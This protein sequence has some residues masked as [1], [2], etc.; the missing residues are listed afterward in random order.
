MERLNYGSNKQIF[1][2]ID[3]WTLERAVRDGTLKIGADILDLI[4]KEKGLEK[5]ALIPKINLL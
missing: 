2:K 3:R 5:V 1:S 4:L